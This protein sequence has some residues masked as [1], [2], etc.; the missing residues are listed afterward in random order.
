M[1]FLYIICLFSVY[2]QY[3][4]SSLS[5]LELQ[6]PE[7]WEITQKDSKIWKNLVIII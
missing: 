1:Y 2:D 6:Y 5:I 3:W 4:A 7:G